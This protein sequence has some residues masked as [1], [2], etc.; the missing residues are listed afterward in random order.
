MIK[1]FDYIPELDC[2]KVTEDFKSIADEL[3]LSEWNEVVWIGRYFTLDNNY[4]EHWFD[5]WKIREINEKK[6][7]SIGYD[8]DDLLFIDPERFENG[9]DGPCHTNEERKRFWT[10]VCKS[11]HMSLETIFA[12]AKKINAELKIVNEP[13]IENI[14]E[15]IIAISKRYT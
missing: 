10:D 12:E 15:V 3:G 6:A 1:V 11:L 13:Y 8:S 9:K 14:E 2:F 5:N 4:G 7:D